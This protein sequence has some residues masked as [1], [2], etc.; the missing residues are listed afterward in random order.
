MDFSNSRCMREFLESGSSDGGEVRSKD[1]GRT[2]L[3]VID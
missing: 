2:S 1:D 3:V